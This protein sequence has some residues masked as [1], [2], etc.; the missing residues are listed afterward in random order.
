MRSFQSRNFVT[1]PPRTSRPLRAGTARGPFKGPALLLRVALAFL[2]RKNWARWV[3]LLFI[4]FGLP[5]LHDSFQQALARSTFTT[6]YFI[7]Q[8]LLQCGVA[9]LLFLKPSNEWFRRLKSTTSTF[10]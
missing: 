3:F 2:R 5:S 4:I 10:T 8:T 9:V 1:L 6:V 7:M